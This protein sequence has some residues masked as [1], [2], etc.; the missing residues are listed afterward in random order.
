MTPRLENRFYN[1]F[2]TS[3]LIKVR[4]EDYRSPFE[5]DRDRIIHTSA[6]RRLQAKT[7]VFLSGEYD[8]YRTRLTHSL[9]V[10]QIGRSICKFLRHESPLLAPDYYI[11]ANLVEAICLS[12]DLGHPPFGHAGE[13]ILNE[14]M[15]PFGGF[16]GNAQTLRLITETI[17]SS[18]GE[19][20]GMNPTRAFVDGILKY[21]TLYSQLDNPTNHFIYDEQKR[22]VD[23][24]FGGASIPDE[25][26]PGKKMNSFRSIECQIMD[27]S[28]D[29]AYSLND[30]S[31]GI[32]SGLITREKIEEWMGNRTLSKDES[33]FGGGLVRSLAE[34]KLEKY[35]AGKIGTFI[36]ATSLSK[37]ENCLSGT[38]SRYGFALEIAP[39]VRMEAELYKKISIDLVFRSPQLHQLEHKGGYVLKKIFNALKENYTETSHSPINLLPRDAEKT[40]RASQSPQQ[41]MRLLCDHIAGMTD[42]FAVRTYKR[43]FDAEFGSLADLI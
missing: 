19:R 32:H 27:W 14:L 15:R 43:L 30:L 36:R 34:G 16:E 41:T 6:F 23:F 17:Y 8:F 22:F 28:D 31:D 5:I 4:E 10:A 29:A 13:R 33:D 24:I 1:S 42:G 18:G 21:K 35:I 37:W 26:T 20:K 7:Q 9:E 40:I 38:T 3:C 2:D 39:A 12:H 11:D 25:L